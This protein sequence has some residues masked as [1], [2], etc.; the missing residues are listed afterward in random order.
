[1]Q[2]EKQTLFEK[3]PACTMSVIIIFLLAGLYGLCSLKIINN[4]YTEFEN[5]S[6]KAL[7]HQYYVGKI[8]DNNIGRFIKLREHPP[9]QVRFE[10][11]S[12]NYIKNN[13][14]AN[15]L[16]RKYYR[17]ATDKHGMIGP[18]EVHDSP[19]LK[20]VFLGGSTTECLYMEENE[21]FPYLVGRE[22]EKILDK[23]I[24]SYNGGVS[25]NESMHSLNIL[26]NKV[27][28]LKPDMVVLM[29]N[30]NDLNVLRS[31]GTYW[32]PNSLKSHIQTS[33]NVFTRFEFPS[34]DREVNDQEIQREFRRNLETFI[35]I[36]QIREIQPVLMT[37]A[38][39]VENFPQYHEFNQIVRELGAAHHILVVD[40]AKEIPATSAYMYD[41][42]HYT[43][44][45][46]KLASLVITAQLAPL[47]E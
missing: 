40:L 17:I 36:C 47:F 35:A 22:L 5:K 23:K 37:Q 32:Y 15:T 34:H 41:T 31:Q 9:L 4:T 39:R 19:D 18:S 25:A 44:Q 8:I 42:Y 13:D 21:R 1:M 28:A 14:H 29:H 2:P 6:I 16:E 46:A 30:I 20:I 45:G 7:L 11:P 10:R 3:Y 33:K 27:L 24:N 43:A 38:N 26:L 12:R